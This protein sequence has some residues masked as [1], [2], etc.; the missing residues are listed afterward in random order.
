MKAEYNFDYCKETL[1]LKDDIE[2]HFVEFGERLSRIRELELY[3]PNYETFGEF[4][5][6]LKIHESKASKLINIYDLFVVKYKFKPVQ[7]S[8]A[9]GWSVL[10]TVLPVI[11]S[12][13]DAIHWLA[14]AQYC[15][16][17]DLEISVREVRKG[18]DMSKCKHKD[19]Y[20]IEICRICGERKQIYKEVKKKK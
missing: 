6:E 17:D 13:K 18:I 16:K 19:T 1:K 14:E 9:G 5:K 11:K 3:Q 15:T 20:Q 8:R 4:C 2:L 12:K 10:A 7:L